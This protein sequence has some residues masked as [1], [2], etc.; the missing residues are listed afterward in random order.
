[1]NTPQ[2]TVVELFAQLGLDDDSRSIESFLAAHS[3]LDESILLEE[4]PF[5]SD[6]Q[7]AFLRSELAR[8]ADWAILID[9]LDA[10]LREPWCPEQTPT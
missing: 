8:D 2:H 4:A 9:R 3:P 1:M 10:R 6:T 7:R 5:W